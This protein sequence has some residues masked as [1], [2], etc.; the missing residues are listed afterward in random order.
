MPLRDGALAMEVFI[1]RSLVEGFFNDDKALSI[2]SY[3]D[4]GAQ[5]MAFFA[6]GELLVDCIQVVR[7]D[8][9]Y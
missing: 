9:I 2:R 4:P 8:S 7:M 3:G 5:R 1:D 6:D